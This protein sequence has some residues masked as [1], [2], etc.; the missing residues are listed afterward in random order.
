MEAVFTIVR[1]VMAITRQSAATSEI[2]LAGI[3]VEGTNVAVA[4]IQACADGAPANAR[5]LLATMGTE[6]SRMRIARDRHM[7]TVH[8]HPGSV[9]RKDGATR[10]SLEQGLPDVAGLDMGPTTASNWLLPGRLLIGAM[11]YTQQD[12]EAY[13]AVGVTTFVCLVGEFG[14][15]ERYLTRT[16]PAMLTDSERQVPHQFLCGWGF[17]CMPINHSNLHKSGLSCVAVCARIPA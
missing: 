7:L 17:I 11:P 14:S 8:R 6:P 5:T 13:L 9:D 12:T 16:Y 2:L 10:P 15:M 4:T 1:R 3:L